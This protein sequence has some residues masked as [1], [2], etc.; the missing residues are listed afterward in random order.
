[1]KQIVRPM[2]ILGIIR[3]VGGGLLGVVV[4]VT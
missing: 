3:I 1:M 4:S 2:V